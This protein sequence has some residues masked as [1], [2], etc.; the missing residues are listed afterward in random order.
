[1]FPFLHHRDDCTVNPQPHINYSKYE[2]LHD[3]KECCHFDWKS[4]N[5]RHVGGMGMENK[6]IPNDDDKILIS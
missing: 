1:M 2:Q 6:S 3:D 5:C 4:Y